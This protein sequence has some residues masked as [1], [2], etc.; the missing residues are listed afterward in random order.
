MR[1]RRLI[2]NAAGRRS[3]G[4]SMTRDIVA[5]IESVPKSQTDQLGLY[6]SVWRR[7]WETVSATDPIQR[8]KVNCA[9]KRI[10]CLDRR[11]RQIVGNNSAGLERIVQIRSVNPKRLTTAER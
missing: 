2:Y 5:N 11:M 3:R 7:R 10:L 8:V 4:C 6:R 1:M 9:T